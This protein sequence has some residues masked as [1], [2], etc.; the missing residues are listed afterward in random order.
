MKSKLY[1]YICVFTAFMYSQVPSH[2]LESRFFELDYEEVAAQSSQATELGKLLAETFN[3]LADLSQ[4]VGIPNLIK[5]CY[6]FLEEI[7]FPE[8]E[9]PVSYWRL[10]PVKKWSC[11][12]KG[13]I[14]VKVIGNKGEQFVQNCDFCRRPETLAALTRHFPNGRPVGFLW[15]THALKQEKEQHNLLHLVTNC[16]PVTFTS[17]CYIPAISYAPAPGGLPAQVCIIVHEVYVGNTKPILI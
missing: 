4:K 7:S 5:N 15:K 13:E 10:P 8:N 3:V 12:W 14:A 9:E 17:I 1:P 16:Q 11:S 6:C 2:A